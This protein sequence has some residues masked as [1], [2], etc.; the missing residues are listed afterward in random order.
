M[1]DCSS[2]KSK[3]LFQV[4]WEGMVV[5]KRECRLPHSPLFQAKYFNF[6]YFE[7]K[8]SSFNHKTACNPKMFYFMKYQPVRK[9]PKKANF[10]K[11]S[12]GTH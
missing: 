9:A 10:V 7:G 12:F 4:S 5:D 8:G 2:S 1:P 11:A 6:M 3:P